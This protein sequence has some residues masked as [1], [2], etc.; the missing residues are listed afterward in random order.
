MPIPP[1]LQIPPKGGLTTL[2]ELIDLASEQLS[3]AARRDIPLNERIR[4]CRAA[5]SLLTAVIGER[6]ND[7]A[8]GNWVSVGEIAG[9]VVARI[10]R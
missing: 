3:F 7:R 8:S 4:L 9:R 1:S 6:D 2:N 10:E 5:R